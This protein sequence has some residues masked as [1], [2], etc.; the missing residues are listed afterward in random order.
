[1]KFVSQDEEAQQDILKKIK[2]FKPKE[3]VFEANAK[4]EEDRS[5]V[6]MQLKRT[7]HTL[8]ME[9]K[10]NFSQEEKEKEEEN[11]MSLTP[12]EPKKSFR[13]ENFYLGNKQENHY[14]TKGL[15]VKDGNPTNLEE[16]MM[17]II[18]DDSDS[19]LKK[20]KYFEMG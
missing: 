17:D 7:E 6:I 19:M 3:T 8:S 15:S 12:F 14:K 1:V 10:K 18:P 5:S 4:D 16:I 11:R 2:Q 13:D 9:K 20:K